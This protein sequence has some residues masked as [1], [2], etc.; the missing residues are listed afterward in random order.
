M[1]WT[2]L[3]DGSL[4]IDQEL[5]VPSESQKAIILARDRTTGQSGLSQVGI[6]ARKD[7]ARMLGR[8]VH[9]FLRVKVKRKLCV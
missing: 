7:I 4:R 3:P 6:R 1:G 8:K 5:H 9:L 2:D